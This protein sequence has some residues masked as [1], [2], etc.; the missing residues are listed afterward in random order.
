MPN[1]RKMLN[2][3]VSLFQIRLFLVGIS[4]FAYWT[5]RAIK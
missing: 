3:Y 1:Y 2:V 4:L 5:Q